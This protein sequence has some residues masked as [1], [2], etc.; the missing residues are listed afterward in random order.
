MKPFKTLGK[1]GVLLVLLN[2][3]RGILVV[4]SILGAWSHAGKAA[5]PPEPVCA[6]TAQPGAACRPLDGAKRLRTAPA[7][8]AQP[9]GSRGASISPQ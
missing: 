5:A 4:A 1:V 7:A 9:S 2:E 8:P 6:A 3:I